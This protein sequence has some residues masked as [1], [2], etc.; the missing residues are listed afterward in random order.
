MLLKKP[1]LQEIVRSLLLFSQIYTAQQL[2]QAGERN[3]PSKAK[4]KS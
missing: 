1:D 2:L 3:T 4:V